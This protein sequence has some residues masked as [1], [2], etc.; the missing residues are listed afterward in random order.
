MSTADSQ[1]LLLIRHA[2]TLSAT[3]Q[4]RDIER[5]LSERGHAQTKQM[6]QHLV[7]IN[8]PQS[9]T[10]LCSPAIRTRQTLQGCLADWDQSK[11]SFV[12]KIYAAYTGDL[13][14]LLDKSLQQQPGWLVLIGHNPS[15]DSIVRWLSQ[16]NTSALTGMATGCIASFTGTGSLSPENWQF[17]QH[18]KPNKTEVIIQSGC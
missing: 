1:Q 12:D 11:I 15:L 10:V 4:Q 7:A 16:N 18:F 3:F 9:A 8:T 5:E 14:N 17:K 6:H 13:V 2:K